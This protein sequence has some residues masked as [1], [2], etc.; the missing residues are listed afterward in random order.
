MAAANV[1][2]F[3]WIKGFTSF[4]L[5][6]SGVLTIIC[7]LETCHVRDLSNTSKTCFLFEH[8]PGHLEKSWICLLN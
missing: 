3:T 2:L 1:M 8:T 7:C 6:D 5:P 4:Y